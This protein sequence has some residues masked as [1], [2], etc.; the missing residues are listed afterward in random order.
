[1]ARTERCALRSSVPW[2]LFGVLA[3]VGARSAWPVSRLA[4]VASIPP[5]CAADS[6]R[7]LDFWLGDWDVYDVGGTTP[8]ARARIT[9]ILDG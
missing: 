8:V 1:M 5:E 3:A 4:A 6:H 7:Q 9:R 2:A